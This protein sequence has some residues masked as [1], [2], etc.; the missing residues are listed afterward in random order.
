MVAGGIIEACQ[1][2]DGKTSNEMSSG[3]NNCPRHRRWFDNSFP[4]DKPAGT[5]GES[6]PGTFGGTDK[7]LADKG[8]WCTFSGIYLMGYI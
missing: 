4:G 7:F 6:I 1:E 3:R 5:R 8:G 2:L